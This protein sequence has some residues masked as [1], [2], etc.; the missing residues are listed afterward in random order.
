MKLSWVDDGSERSV[1]L[2]VLRPK[3]S[4]CDLIRSHRDQ[5]RS[6]VISH[7]CLIKPEL[8]R[9]A[10]LGQSVIDVRALLAKTG[11]FT[12]DP[13]F[14]STSSCE[15]AITYIDGDAGYSPLT[16]SESPRLFISAISRRY[17]GIGVLLHR[18]YHINALAEQCSFP[19]VPRYRRDIAEISPRYRRDIAEMNSRDE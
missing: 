8:I 5:S 2:P 6:A 10:G 16:S 11:F 9:Q 18:G 12:H 19:E 3:V 4:A 13:G 17:L 7:S 1:D 14:T 15:S